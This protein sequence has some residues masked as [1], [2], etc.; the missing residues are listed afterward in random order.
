MAA[1][2]EEHRVDLHADTIKLSDAY[3]KRT[4]DGRWSLH[5]MME[6]KGVLSDGRIVCGKQPMA[7]YGLRQIGRREPGAQEV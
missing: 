1:I 7:L 4:L 6:V 3:Y 5:G 2:R